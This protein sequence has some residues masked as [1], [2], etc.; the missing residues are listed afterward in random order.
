MTTI[1]QILESGKLEYGIYYFLNRL[2]KIGSSELTYK[3]EMELHYAQNSKNRQPYSAKKSFWINEKDYNF[4]ATRWDNKAW[5][6]IAHDIRQCELPLPRL[7][8]TVAITVA[9]GLNN[10]RKVTIEFTVFIKLNEGQIKER[11]ERL[12]KE[13]GG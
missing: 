6:N 9:K 12:L 11:F 3:P 2:I 4:I 5:E 10:N 8:T 1:Q 7:N 13:Y